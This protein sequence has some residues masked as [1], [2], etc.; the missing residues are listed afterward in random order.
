MK[1]V[2]ALI[3]FLLI[4]SQD[5]HRS[6]FAAAGQSAAGTVNGSWRR[7]LKQDENNQ[8]KAHVNLN[9]YECPNNDAP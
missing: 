7:V 1:L 8:V 2:S 9:E 3:I 4:A 6:T 5:G